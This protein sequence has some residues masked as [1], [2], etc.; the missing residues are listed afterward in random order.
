[1]RASTAPAEPFYSPKPRRLGRRRIGFEDAAS[2]SAVFGQYLEEIS[3]ALGLQTEH[4]AKSLCRPAFRVERP[5]KLPGRRFVDTPVGVR[6]HQ[7]GGRALRLSA[8]AQR[9]KRARHSYN[10]LV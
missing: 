5:L 2:M 6:L 8:V 1:M 9:A 3:A 4:G 10:D 7:Q